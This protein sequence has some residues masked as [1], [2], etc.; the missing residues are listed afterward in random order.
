MDNYSVLMPSYTIGGD[1]YKLIKEYCCAY[2]KT[3]VIIGGHTALSKAEKEIRENCA[4]AIEITATLWYG[5]ECSYENVA[6][7]KERSEVSGADMIFAVGG[8]K[9]VDT[10]KALGD[11]LSKPVFTFPTIA[12]NCA[13][14]TAVSIMYKPD[15][16]FIEPYFFLHVPVH[17]FINTRILC[18]APAK[19]LWAGMG[20]TY[21]KYY[22]ATISARGENPEH[23]KAFGLAMSS[24][25]KEPVLMY[26]KT[27]LQDNRNQKQ[28]YEFQQT[29]LAICITTGFVSIF[30]TRDHTPD[31][32]SG[33]AHAV[34]YTLTTIGIE[35]K[36]LHGE[37]VALG[38]LFCLLCDRQNEEYERLREFNLSVGLP[39]KLS[40]I[41]VS[42]EQ[43]ELLLETIT[44]MSD[45]RHY[46]YKVT[47]E[48]LKN[49]LEILS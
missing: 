43:F 47:V 29:V 7:L 30:L 17:T 31:Y 6:L 13:C 35:E 26:G 5:G 48:M 36:H 19:Y 4:D 1:S 40:D 10:C 18:E 27:A 42:R 24:M 41:E 38:T 33:L 16:S 45:I 34:F 23:F 46:P 11:K 8:G 2:G 22:E 21:A 3:A 15:G 28:S 14:C 37:V 44:S 25:C 9:A 49:A 32:N 20:D 39:T 12:S